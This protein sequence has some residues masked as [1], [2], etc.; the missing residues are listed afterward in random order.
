MFPL[1]HKWC[2][3]KIKIKK[4]QDMVIKVFVK[5]KSMANNWEIKKPPQKKQSI[6]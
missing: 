1:N 5:T 6:N 4:N 2:I 3:K